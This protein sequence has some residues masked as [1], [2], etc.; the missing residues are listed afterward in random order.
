MAVG[1]EVVD[2][3]ELGEVAVVVEE[4]GDVV[5]EADEVV[6]VVD[7]MVSGTKI[8]SSVEMSACEGT[9]SRTGWGGSRVTT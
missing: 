8:L 4:D 2:M 5:E 3:A 7:G 6:A 1:E 9:C